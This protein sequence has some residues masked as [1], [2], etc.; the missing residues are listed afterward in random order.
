MNIGSPTSNKCGMDSR[1]HMICFSDW[2]ENVMLDAVL[3]VSM[4]QK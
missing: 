1:Y 2:P 4:Q 3:F